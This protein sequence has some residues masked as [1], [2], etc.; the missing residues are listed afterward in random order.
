VEDAF[1]EEQKDNHDAA[2]DEGGFFGFD[3]SGLLAYVDDHGDRSED[4]NHRKQ[5]E[6]D[7][8][9]FREIECHKSELMDERKR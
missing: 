3:A 9:N 8:Y 6:R 4:V 5:D 2:G 7:G 1:A